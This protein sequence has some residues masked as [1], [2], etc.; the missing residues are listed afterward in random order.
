MAEAEIRATPVKRDWA[1]K[2]AE[3][4]RS[5]REFADKARVPEAVPLL[6]GMGAGEI[7][8]GKSPEGFENLAYDMPMT[9]GK[10]WT[11]RLKP[12]TIDMGFLGMDAIGAGQLLKAGA[13]PLA[14][15]GAE[16]I[17]RAMMEGTGP[18]ANALSPVA[19]NFAV[20]PGTK[21]L[22]SVRS[23]IEQADAAIKESKRAGGKGIIVN[24]TEDL[25]VLPKTDSPYI[26]ADQFL[27]DRQNPRM[28][29]GE[30]VY[31]ERTA[32]LLEDPSARRAIERNILRGDAMGMREWYGT[33]PLYEAA[34]DAGQTP[35]EFTRMMQHLSSAS[36]RSPVP[37]QI[38]RGSATWVAD[39][40]GLLTPDAPEYKLPPGYGSMAQKQIIENAYKIA[41]GEGLDTSKKLGRF[42]ENLTGNLEPVTV[43]VM[44]MRGPIMA[45]KDPRWLARELREQN[46]KTGEIS[47][48]RPR[49]MFEKGEITMADALQ[50]PGFWE[51][52]P[53]GAEYGAFED[54]YRGI[55]KKRG[56]A[57]AEA[58][59]NA[60]YGS[61]SDAGLRSAPRTFMQAVEDRIIDTA[62]KRNE[63]YSQVLADF[64]R[65]KKP[66][67]GVGAG[68][69]L[70]TGEENE[71]LSPAQ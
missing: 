48:L 39:K 64:L 32:D 9:T 6:G 7:L 3:A 45:T 67:M 50:R 30:P 27:P 41:G 56:M 13:K 54:L 55:A 59:A 63:T 69:G 49:E 42:N 11:T 36:Q 46:A 25:K 58:Q 10:G 1:L 34:M 51:A 61:G 21:G 66:L 23:A 29:N 17:N 52:A 65:G 18:L 60:W 43:D 68:V 4:L 33:K 22:T 16:Q 62:G 71:P 70:G 14:R 47:I 8:L 31:N 24:K 37:G 28:K 35:E 2:L 38:K 26:E 12:E 20:A 40:Q 44:A 5:T 19:P 57:P 53:Q 15:A